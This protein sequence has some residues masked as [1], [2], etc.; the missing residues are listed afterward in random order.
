MAFSASHAVVDASSLVIITHELESLIKTIIAGKITDPHEVLKITFGSNQAPTI[1]QILEAEHRRLEW[2]NG[3][4]IEA[5]TAKQFWHK[6]LT[7]V[8]ELSIMGSVPQHRNGQ[9]GTITI[10]LDESIHSGI[11]NLAIVCG[12]TPFIVLL[13][14]Y[15]VVL[16]EATTAN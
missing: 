5:N 3:S 11:T 14:A 8:N 13:T 6:M 15:M 9:G 1:D 4:S 2:V 16:L 12:C 10:H 7:D